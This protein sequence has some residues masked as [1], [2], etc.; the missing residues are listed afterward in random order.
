MKR[1]RNLLWNVFHKGDMLLL[2]LCVIATIFGIVMISAVMGEEGGSRNM[3]IQIVTLILG[4][5][6]YLFFTAFD[7]EI[8]TGQRTLLFLFNLFFIG[9]LLVFGVEG[10]TGNKSWTIWFFSITINKSMCKTHK[11]ENT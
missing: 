11:E 4:V 8:L 3:T 10:E 1:F 2:V 6:L 5:V 9:L 7:I